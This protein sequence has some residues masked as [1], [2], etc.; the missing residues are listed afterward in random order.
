MSVAVLQHVEE[1]LESRKELKRRELS[2]VCPMWLRRLRRVRLLGGI[3]IGDPSKSWDVLKTVQALEAELPKDASILDIGSFA[4]ELICILQK[5]GYQNLTGIDLDP[6]IAKMPNPQQ[7]SRFVRGNFMQS[8][9]PEESLDAVTAISV[10][11]HGFDCKALLQRVSRI[12][13]PGGLFLASVDYWPDKI[14]TAGLNPFGLKWNIFS[15]AELE[16]LMATAAGV[17]LVPCG[18]THYDSTDR[19]V[20]WL[21]KAYTFA[22]FALRKAK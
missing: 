5:L 6:R 2:F 4:S 8:E 21:G 3:N 20:K 22:W 10:I 15:R 12:L 17:G 9:F 1:N 13:K 19:T 16:S 18:P 11:E 7:N 14:V